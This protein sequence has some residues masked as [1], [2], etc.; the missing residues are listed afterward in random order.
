METQLQP[1]AS[2]VSKTWTKAPPLPNQ[3]KAYIPTMIMEG[4]SLAPVHYSAMIKR[5]GRKTGYSIARL[6][7]KRKK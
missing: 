4:E 7:Q 6:H 1:T 5:N 3:V 2:I